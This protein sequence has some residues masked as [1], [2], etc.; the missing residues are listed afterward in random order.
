MCFPISDLLQ[1]YTLMRIEQILHVIDYRSILKHTIVQYFI[2][3]RLS[4]QK[5]FLNN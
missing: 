3:Y 1:Q 4:A 5:L 2:W